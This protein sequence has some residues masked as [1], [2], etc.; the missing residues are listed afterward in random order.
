MALVTTDLL[1]RGRRREYAHE[2]EATL[3]RFTVAK[4]PVRVR[5]EDVRAFLARRSTEVGTQTLVHELSRLRAFFSTLVERGRL[6]HDPTEGLTVKFEGSG[7]QRVLV[8]TEVR[9]LLVASSEETCDVRRRNAALGLRDRACV[10]LLFGLGLRREELARARVVDLGLADGTLLV[11]RVKRGQGRLLP[12]PPA[13]VA[14]VA[15][16]LAEGRSWFL[17]L[18]TD[19]AGSIFLSR[20]GTPLRGQDVGRL[21]RRAA[22]RANLGK[23]GPHALRRSLATELV[24]AK[25]SLPAVQELLGHRSLGT[26]AHYLVLD[27]SDL[28]DAVRVLDWPR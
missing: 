7:P 28:H 5:V 12:V 25:A 9:A 18:G 1:R 20:F 11:R 27:R 4:L 2:V 23:L 16:Y 14:S 24:R 22:R 10:E 3:R 17:R 26:T 19:D 15:R 8:P 6:A 21:V 13:V